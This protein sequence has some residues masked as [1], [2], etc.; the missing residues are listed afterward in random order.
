MKK[1]ILCGASKVYKCYEGTNTQYKCNCIGDRNT[2][3][4]ISIGYYILVN[5]YNIIKQIDIGFDDI[6]LSF[7]NHVIFYKDNKYILN[8]HGFNNIEFKEDIDYL[9]KIVRRLIDN[10]IFM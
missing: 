7:Y 6:K 4:S 5:D 1:C 8:S 9:D 3:Y 2:Y 10:L